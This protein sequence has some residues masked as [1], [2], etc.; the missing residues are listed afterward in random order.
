MLRAGFGLF[1]DLLPGSIADL[2]GTNPPYVR[3]FRAACWE[4]SAAWISRRAC[5]TAPWTRWRRRT[6][7]SARAFRRARFPAHH[8]WQSAACLPPVA[9]TAVPSGELHAPYFMEWS[10]A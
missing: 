4:P 9:I 8:R 10:R 6:R 1:S 2:I 3:T 7:A 5:R